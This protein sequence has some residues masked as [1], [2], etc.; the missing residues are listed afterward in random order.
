MTLS[1]VRLDDRLVHGQVV[2]GWGR[3]LD[4]QLVVLVDDRVRASEW[5]QDL[6]RMGIPAEVELRFASVPEAIAAA[7]GWLASPLRTIVVTGDVDTLAQL[8]EGS[9]IRRVNIGGIHQQPHRSKRLPYVYLSDDEASR[10][11]SLVARGVD[12]SAQDVPTARPVP[13]GEFT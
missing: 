12:V 7:P 1:L 2:V 6:Y 4:V 8:V 3:A 13:L 9:D 5:E 10:L 11:V